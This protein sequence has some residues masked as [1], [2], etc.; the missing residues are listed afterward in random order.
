MLLSRAS[1]GDA[2]RRDDDREGETTAVATDSGRSGISGY[3]RRAT[4]IYGA[5]PGPAVSRPGL[6][7]ATESRMTG[8]MR[9]KF[10]RHLA[11]LTGGRLT[12]VSTTGSRSL[13]EVAPGESLVLVRAGSLDRERRLFTH[14]RRPDA[15]VLLE[16]PGSV[17]AILIRE[18]NG[19]PIVVPAEVLLADTEQDAE[20][21][22]LHIR[23][24]RDGDVTHVESGLDLRPYLGWAQLSRLVAGQSGVVTRSDAVPFLTHSEWQTVVAAIARRRRGFDLW[25]PPADRTALCSRLVRGAGGGARGGLG[26]VD[27]LPAGGVHL[28]RLRFADVVLTRQGARWPTLVAEVEVGGDITSALARCGQTLADLRAAGARPLPRFI[29]VADSRRR[30]EFQQK[31]SSALYAGPGGLATRCE[32]WSFERVWA[33]YVR[34]RPAGKRRPPGQAAA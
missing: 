1:P 22:P 32:M 20:Y 3:G 14:I 19:E 18:L 21:V 6:T 24:G 28:R 4:P 11:R 26:R 16:R 31:L 25:V 23:V 9:R 2:E 12:R 34:R 8:P 13:I 30:A 15:L 29:V 17:V 7:P 10:S 5:L 33:A 27:I